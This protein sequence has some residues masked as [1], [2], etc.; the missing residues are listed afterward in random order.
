MYKIK[1]YMTHNA[2]SKL[3]E[4]RCTLIQSFLSGILI[5]SIIGLLTIILQLGLFITFLKLHFS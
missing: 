4:G 3:F 2:L 1:G 5:S